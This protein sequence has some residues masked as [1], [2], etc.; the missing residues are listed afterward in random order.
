MKW[1]K[2]WLQEE[3]IPSAKL[4]VKEY[5]PFQKCDT[6]E[7][8]M[9]GSTFQSTVEAIRSPFAYW[10][11]NHQDLKASDERQELIAKNKEANAKATS[12][13][14]PKQTTP[15]KESPPERVSEPSK[16]TVID[17]EEWRS[18]EKGGQIIVYY[19]K[20]DGIDTKIA[21]S[22]EG[23]WYIA[24]KIG[25]KWIAKGNAAL[26]LEDFKA[27]IMWN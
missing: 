5:E 20:I 11:M 26:D 21:L 17:I 12:T 10:Y 4:V 15:K 9:I 19:G 8:C 16:P 22:E 14:A 1:K 7:A 23:K 18:F 24:Q 3:V 6:T 2:K 27:N 25:D 13:P